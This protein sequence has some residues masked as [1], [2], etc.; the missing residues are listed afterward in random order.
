MRAEI[1]ENPAP[2][3]STK[4]PTVVELEEIYRRQVER[5][6]HLL[7]GSNQLVAANTLL[8]S[9][10]G[11]VRLFADEDARDGMAIEIRGDVSRILLHGPHKMT[12]GL[13]KEALSHL[14]QISVVAGGVGFEP[15]TFRL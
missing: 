12:K 7:T 5:L 4:L 9:L 10:L 3:E 11:E 8:K 2:A 1:S 6:E 14:S 13:P 15:T